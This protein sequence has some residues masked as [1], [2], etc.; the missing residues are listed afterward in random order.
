MESP[1]KKPFRV[2]QYL[3][4]QGARGRTFIALLDDKNVFFY[5]EGISDID[6]FELMRPALDKCAESGK[7][8]IFSDGEF[9]KAS[10]PANRE[11]WTQ[12]F[13]ANP[14][15]VLA[16]NVLFPS[17][18]FQ[19]ALNVVTTITGQEMTPFPDA[20]AFYLKLR[21]QV[22][23]IIRQSRAWPADIGDRISK[24]S[25]GNRSQRR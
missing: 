15:K 20:G 2:E 9:N 23:S 19:M 25:F 5:F 18:I 22:P 14:G 21:T 7:V 12:W 1:Q 10:T 13:Q 24:T 11:A 6:S 16:T 3:D 4:Y 8:T 17:Q